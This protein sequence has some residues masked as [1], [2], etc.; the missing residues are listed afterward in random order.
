MRLIPLAL[1]FSLTSLPLCAKRF[2]LD[3]L[4]RIVR[5]SDPQLSPDNR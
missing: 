5:V 4:S 2:D 3:D 1:L